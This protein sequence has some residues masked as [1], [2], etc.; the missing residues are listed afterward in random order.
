[1]S[2]RILVFVGKYVQEKTLAGKKGYHYELFNT[3][4]CTNVTKNYLQE[5][6]SWDKSG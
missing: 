4:G 2:K 1:M 6:S 5:A 3:V